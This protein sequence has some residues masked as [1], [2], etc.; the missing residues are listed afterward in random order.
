VTD[1]V[2]D[3]KFRGLIPTQHAYPGNVRRIPKISHLWKIFLLE[4]PLNIF[5]ICMLC[6]LYC[7]IVCNVCIFS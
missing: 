2:Q 3:K 6:G 4:C 7:V 1:F 5:W